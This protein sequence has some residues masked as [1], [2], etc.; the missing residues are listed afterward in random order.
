[1]R[2][3][4]AV[5]FT[6]YVTLIFGISLG[7]W[8]QA[9]ADF[10]PSL[11]LCLYGWLLYV[12]WAK[13]APYAPIA[14]AAIA[15]VTAIVAIR[16]IFLQRD[17]ARRRAAIDFFLK[18]EMDET[19]IALYNKFKNNSSKFRRWA[20]AENPR[21]DPDYHDARA[22]LNICEL[23]A[24]GVNH[25]AFSDT[26]SFAYWCDVICDSYKSASPLIERIRRTP[27]LGSRYTY[28]DLE[29]LHKAWVKKN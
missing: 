26:V 4:L 29:K 24:V 13:I 5:I 18:T 21:S 3:F 9:D 10:W 8:L 28:T 6:A 1:M 7:A 15:L 22:F 27:D 11:K 12:P 20:E 25:G 16:A 17:I 19:I 2:T 23:I 14:T